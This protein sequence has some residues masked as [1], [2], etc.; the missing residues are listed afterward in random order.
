MLENYSEYS[1][2]TR[3]HLYL[4]DIAKELF[5]KNKLFDE[6]YIPSSKFYEEG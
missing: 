4:F 3:N 5:P 2:D 1:I 6:T